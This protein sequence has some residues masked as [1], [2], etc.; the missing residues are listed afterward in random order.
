[1]LAV[2]Q[3]TEQEELCMTLMDPLQNLHVSI[4]G[5]R[6]VGVQCHCPLVGSRTDGSTSITASRAY[7]GHKQYFQR[8]PLVFFFFFFVFLPLSCLVGLVPTGSGSL[9]LASDS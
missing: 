5:R 7:P 9:L 4:R 2:C 8:L 6:H 1:M 3:H